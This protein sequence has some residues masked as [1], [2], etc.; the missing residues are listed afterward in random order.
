MTT[1]R[2]GL[3]AA[4]IAGNGKTVYCMFN[5]EH[6]SIKKCNV[7]DQ[8]KSKPKPDKPEFKSFGRS[9]LTLSSLLF[10]TY[11]TDEDLIAKT[12]ELWGFM[13]PVDSND[14]KS[15]PPEV[16]FKWSSF[17]FKAVITDMEMKY[18]LFKSNGTPVRAE[19][20]VTFMQSD[21]PTK[22]P[23]QNPT[24]GA[25]QVMEI[26]RIIQGDRLDLI[27]AEVYGDATEWRR[28]AQHNAIMNPRTLRPGQLISIP[29]K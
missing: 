20:T 1:T 5:P 15:K 25:D 16:T 18:T 9:T 14:P 22:Y 10:D 19:V 12:K 7:Y 23:H 29:P 13:Q 21:D 6:Y 4:S 26:R 24:S 3:T 27:A 2:S 8:G 28:I 11:E 17:Q